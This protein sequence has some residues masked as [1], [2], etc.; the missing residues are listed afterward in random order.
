MIAKEVLHAWKRGAKELSVFSTQFC[1]EIKT[2][3]KNSLWKKREE[4]REKEAEKR[5]RE[6]EREQPTTEAQNKKIK[7]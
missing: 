7:V 5:V 2:V 3:L 1:S 4:E 6:R